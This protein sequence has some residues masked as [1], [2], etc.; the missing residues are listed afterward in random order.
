MK[1]CIK[2]L[3][4]FAMVLFAVSVSKGETA[5]AW[6]VP[7]GEQKFGYRGSFDGIG[8]KLGTAE[9][10]KCYPE[11]TEK[12]IRTYL[13]PLY[14]GGR[15]YE[16][17]GFNLPYDKNGYRGKI[18]ALLPDVDTVDNLSYD[19][20]YCL[21]NL[22]ILMNG[23][24]N[25]QT[26]LVLEVVK[27]GNQGTGYRYALLSH[28][29]DMKSLV[30]DGLI[31]VT[32]DSYPNTNS[33]FTDHYTINCY[34]LS[35]QIK[36]YFPGISVVQNGYEEIN[37]QKEHYGHDAISGELFGETDIY[38]YGRK[39]GYCRSFSS[40]VDLTGVQNA[41]HVKITCKRDAVPNV[42]LGAQKQSNRG[43][44]LKFSLVQ[45]MTEKRTYIYERDVVTESLANWLWSGY[46]DVTYRKDWI[47]NYLFGYPARDALLNDFVFVREGSTA[48]G[49][50]TL[51]VCIGES[52]LYYLKTGYENCK[53]AEER[54][55]YLYNRMAGTLKNKK[56]L[57]PGKTYK[58]EF[59]TGAKF[60]YSH[61]NYVGYVKKTVK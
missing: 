48:R 23:Q 34:T 50:T 29:T 24:K 36:G 13:K 22:S 58:I 20:L 37:F 54:V 9:E 55:N 41:T 61:G 18:V 15:M 6:E 19:A 3:V 40:K 8:T 33:T 10:Q 47:P 59:Y 57:T 53:T 27:I 26:Q 5:S 43:F 30:T 4:A 2:L 12:F 11:I 60:F 25:G 44:E 16:Y 46:G 1:K 32:E 17:V 21:E 56:Y 35:V 28:G 51:I 49:V 31:T 45:D 39:G 38:P 52:N 14:D 42:T 7:I